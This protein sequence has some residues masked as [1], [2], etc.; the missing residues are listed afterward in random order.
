VKKNQRAAYLCLVPF[1]ALKYL[2]MSE[3]PKVQ[4]P[5]L[6]AFSVNTAA[7]GQLGF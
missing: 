5:D 2:A 4:Y 3:F 1:F 6:S 7:F